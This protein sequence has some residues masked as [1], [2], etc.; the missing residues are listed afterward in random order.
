M[1][2]HQ[3]VRLNHWHR[4]FFKILRIESWH[5][6]SRS[7]IDIKR[8]R[9]RSLECIFH[10]VRGCT[11]N[12]IPPEGIHYP[13]CTS[14]CDCFSLL[15]IPTLFSCF[16]LPSIILV[17]SSSLQTIKGI[18]HFFA[19]SKVFLCV[20]TTSTFLV[21]LKKMKIEPFVRKEKTVFFFSIFRSRYTKHHSAFI[22]NT[23]LPLPVSSA[24]PPKSQPLVRLSS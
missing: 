17:V 1:R 10:I 21:S 8:E 15:N 14:L 12:V 2:E 11:L 9:M 18:H 13:S 19:M 16:Y 3:S 4:S 20:H 22:S 24:I 5:C 6:E 7:H 23:S